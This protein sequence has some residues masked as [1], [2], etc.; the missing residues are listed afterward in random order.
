MN[1]C[2]G[3]VQA[4]IALSLALMG[5]T[6][7]AQDAVAL[8][9][10]KAQAAA[11]GAEQPSKSQVTTPP[12]EAVAAQGSQEPSALFAA[13]K[14][15]KMSATCEYEGQTVTV[16]VLRWETGVM[17]SKDSNGQDVRQEFQYP[18][19]APVPDFH[20]KGD[21]GLCWDLCRH[22]CDGYGVCWLSC[23]YHC[24]SQGGPGDPR[25]P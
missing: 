8:A 12:S 13:P 17:T 20:T 9:Q 3:L 11:V 6:G 25:R 15:L 18:I 4:G 10:L 14:T 23:T 21:G 1:R 2:R 22:V 5:G 16:P 7:Y 24:T 19:L